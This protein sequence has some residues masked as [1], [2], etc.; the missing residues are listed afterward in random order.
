MSR[1]SFLVFSTLLGAFL[2]ICSTVFSQ[3]LTGKWWGL[4]TLPQIELRIVIQIDADSA[5]YHTVL[6]SP[7]QGPWA[8]PLTSFHFDFPDIKFTQTNLNLS[9]EG[10][11]DASYS[12]ITGTFNQNENTAGLIFTRDSIPPSECSTANI[13]SKYTKK[14][15]YIT[16]RDSVR[17]F[18]SY[19]IPKDTTKTYPML[20]IRT[21]YNSEPGGQDQFN[22]MIGFYCRFIKENYIMVFQDVRGRYMSEGIFEDIRPFIP[23]KR[24]N[25]DID[26]ASDTWDAVDWLVKNVSHNNGKVGVSGISYPGF[27]ATMAIL[28][29]HSAIKAVSPQAPVTNWF[30]GDDFHHNGAMFLLDCFTFYQYFG[31]QKKEPSREEHS[32][33]NWPEQDSYQYLLEQGSLS[34]IRKKFFG[35]SAKF[36]NEAFAHPDYDSFWKSR[37]PRQYLRNVKPAVMTVGGWFDAEDLYGTL[38]TYNAIEEQNPPDHPNFLVMGPWAHAQWGFSSSGENMGNI[39]FG[40]DV[41][42]PFHEL[43][44]KFFDHYLLGKASADFDE[45]RIFVTGE[46]QW[47]SFETWPPEEATETFI[48]LQPGGGLAFEPPTADLSYD[49]YMT[50][51]NRPVPYVEKVHQYRTAEYMN[52]DQRFASKRPDVMVFKTDTLTGDVTLAGPITAELFVSTTGTD[53]DYVVKL[54]DVFPEYTQPNDQQQKNKVVMGGYQMLVRAEVMR[55][56]YRNSFEKPEPFVPGEITRV[57]FE[58]QDVAHTFKMGHRIMIQVQHSWFP[59]VDR[60]PQKFINI[61]TCSEEDFQKATQR[62]Y[63]DKEHPSAIK[64]NMLK[65]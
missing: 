13:Q 39:Y 26:E 45:A 29:A 55:G 28:S 52:D 11:V 25:K 46:N 64:V 40:Q 56:K 4:L 43:E 32:T 35:D 59:L 60:N 42:K 36:W 41:I 58:L 18:T 53:A 54:I 7:D 3:S 65:E 16:M 49:E 33:F 2:F 38:H 24:S 48:Y 17:L 61:Y 5:G 47:K 10:W 15:V 30:L 23:D 8:I 14:E 63:H 50:D 44:V 57:K 31:E 22:Y 21:P 20:F 19:Y 34:S 27:Y 9:Y 12:K 37:D 6:L 1:R 51:P 62:L